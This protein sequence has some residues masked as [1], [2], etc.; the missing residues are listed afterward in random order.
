M[1]TWKNISVTI[2]LI[3]RNIF[4]N[5]ALSNFERRTRNMMNLKLSEVVIG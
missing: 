5:N 4:Q 2:E 1:L 3:G